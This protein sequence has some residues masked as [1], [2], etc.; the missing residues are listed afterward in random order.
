MS[1]M[2]PDGQDSHVISDDSEQKTVGKTLQIHPTQVALPNCKGLRSPGR[3]RKRT[4][5]F[6][7]EVVGEY[8]SSNL[9]IVRH[10]L[11]DIGVNP[12][13]GKP[14]ASGLATLLDL[15][16]QP[17]QRN[18][19]QRVCLELGIPPPC[20]ANAFVFIMEKR[21]QRFQQLSGEKSA[22]LLGQV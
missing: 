14:A 8:V 17:L 1:A 22:L 18:T 21:R 4:V 13:G 6:C 11:F 12:P 20:F 7:V 10:D 16:P 2:M 19:E 15:L 5:S 9:L 3:F